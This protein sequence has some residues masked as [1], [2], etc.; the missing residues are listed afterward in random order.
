MS[1]AAAA[2]RRLRRL[3]RERAALGEARFDALQL[4]RQHE[5]IERVRERSRAEVTSCRSRP[6]CAWPGAYRPGAGSGCS[7]EASDPGKT[8]ASCPSG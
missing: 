1:P 3:E 8:S 7:T 6:T 5:R 2:Q 4:Q